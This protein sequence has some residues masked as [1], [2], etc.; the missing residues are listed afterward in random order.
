MYQ[1]CHP[2]HARTQVR[3][4]VAPQH[5]VSFDYSPEEARKRVP[6]V[7]SLGNRFILAAHAGMELSGKLLTMKDDKLS[8]MDPW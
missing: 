1:T 4:T 5:S 6:G 7:E 8:V 3:V 2:I